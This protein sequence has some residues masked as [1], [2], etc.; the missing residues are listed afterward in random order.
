MCMLC[1]AMNPRNLAADGATHLPNSASVGGVSPTGTG[2]SA[3][4]IATT[5]DALALQLTTGY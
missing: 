4:A 2:T 5:L 3:P 1:A